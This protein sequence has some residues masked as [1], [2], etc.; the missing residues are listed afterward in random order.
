MRTSPRAARDF[1][2]RALQGSTASPPCAMA[3]ASPASR[4]LPGRT[5]LEALA[6]EASSDEDSSAGAGSHARRSRRS[7]RSRTAT[8]TRPPRRDAAPAGGGADA[9]LSERLLAEVLGEPDFSPSP[10]SPP[11]SP[12]R[13]SGCSRWFGGRTRRWVSTSTRTSLLTTRPTRPRHRQPPRHPRRLRRARAAAAPPP[14]AG[15]VARARRRSCAGCGR[16]T[17]RWWRRCGCGARR[18][19]APSVGLLKVETLQGSSLLLSGPAGGRET[20]GRARSRCTRRS[21]RWARRLAP[22]SSST[23]SRSS[24]RCSAA[25]ATTPPRR[26]RRRRRAAPSAGSTSR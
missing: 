19:H 23:A 17:L 22:S 12:R 9:E 8:T 10:S 2:P 1:R 15:A 3:T 26:R 21:S 5:T 16:A 6:A 18:R 20:G 4:K 14:S 7:S 24:R 11:D 25:P 13:A